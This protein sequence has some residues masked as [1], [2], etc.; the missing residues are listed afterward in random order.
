MLGYVF[1]DVLRVVGELLQEVCQF[2]I[3]VNLIERAE[4]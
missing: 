4:G 1:W 2:E 3:F